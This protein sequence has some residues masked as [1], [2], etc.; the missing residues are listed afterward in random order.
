MTSVVTGRR[1]LQV[2]VLTASNAARRDFSDQSSRADVTPDKQEALT[3]VLR[4]HYFVDK[5]QRRGHDRGC[6]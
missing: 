6:L 3:N 4:G 2:T 1:F 5:W